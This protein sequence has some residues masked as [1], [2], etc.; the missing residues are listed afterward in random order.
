MLCLLIPSSTLGTSLSIELEWATQTSDDTIKVSLNPLLHAHLL[1]TI[2]SFQLSI[3]EQSPQKWNDKDPIPKPISLDSPKNLVNTELVKELF[4]TQRKY[5]GQQLIKSTKWKTTNPYIW[6]AAFVAGVLITEHNLR[7]GTQQQQLQ[8]SWWILVGV[9][10][11]CATFPL[12]GLV[13]DTNPVWKVLK[14]F[15][16]MLGLGFIS[17]AFYY[18]LGAVCLVQSVVSSAKAQQF[19]S[20]KWCRWFGKISFSLYLT[21]IPILYTL[22]SSL[23]VAFQGNDYA[24]YMAFG[25]SI[26][27]MI[28][29][30]AMFEQWIDTPSL[31]LS[32]TI[33]KKLLGMPP[34][35]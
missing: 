32:A 23:F 28:G 16:G 35:S 19:L 13:M 2:K 18:I 21:H 30:A 17:Y 9:A 5:K 14:S 3:Q 20:Q 10:Y 1:Q 24:S 11:I 31:Q 12:F 29:V 6:Y 34:T 33:G 27:V 15:A 26:P 22:T 25:L 7:P 4:F 8:L